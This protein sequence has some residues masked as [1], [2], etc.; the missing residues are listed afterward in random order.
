MVEYGDGKLNVTIEYGKGILNINVNV[1]FRFYLNV[2][3][4][5]RL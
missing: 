2:F 1:K 3:M 4:Q 5:F